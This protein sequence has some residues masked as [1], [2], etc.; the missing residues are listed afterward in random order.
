MLVSYAEALLILTGRAPQGQ[1]ESVISSS[2][3]PPGSSLKRKSREDRQTVK[4]ETIGGVLDDGYSWRKY[5]AKEIKGFKFPRRYYRCAQER[6]CSA[7]KQV[8][9]SCID[10]T[11]FEVKYIREHTC[12][13]GASAKTGIIGDPRKDALRVSVNSPP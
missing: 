8:H 10:P 3:D 6:V 9:R 13:A 5:G 7:R 4:I 11:K 2:S 12:Q 1:C